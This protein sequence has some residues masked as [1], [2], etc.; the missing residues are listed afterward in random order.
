MLTPTTTMLGRRLLWL[1][2]PDSKD[3]SHLAVNFDGAGLHERSTGDR[4]HPSMGLSNRHRY[5]EVCLI[6]EKDG[7][8]K[9]D[10]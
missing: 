10:H 8:L 6:T 1:N 3:C 9:P 2:S 4:D 7:S 5:Q